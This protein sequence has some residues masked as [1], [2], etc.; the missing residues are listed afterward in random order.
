MKRL[1]AAAAAT[2]LVS[3]V[4]AQ[5]FEAEGARSAASILPANHLRSA[6]HQVAPTVAVRGNDYHFTIQTEW[7]PITASS[8]D[9]L[10]I[11]L[12]EIAAIQAIGQISK[13]EVYMTAAA[14]AATAPLRTAGSLITDPAGTI[15]SA[16]RGVASMLDRVGG[17]G[18]RSRHDDDVV[19][20][21]GGGASAK[22]EIAYAYRVS[23]YSSNPVLQAK[24][25]E[26]AQ[27]ATLGGFTVTAASLAVPGAAGLAFSIGRTTEDLTA[28]LRDKTPRELREA[29]RQTLLA[30][31]VPPADVE[32]FLANDAYS[33]TQQTY[34]VQSLAALRGVRQI[35]H[36]V[37]LAADAKDEDDAFLS[38]RIAQMTAG[39][40][41][42]VKR[43]TTLGVVRNVPLALT[44]DNVVLVLT[45]MDEV[46]WTPRIAH[47]TQA[48][49][50]TVTPLKP[51]RKELWIAGKISPAAKRELASRGWTVI[52]G[53]RGRLY[54]P[55]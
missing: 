48:V 21:V 55:I 5:Q 36:F 11:R 15:A 12:R 41:R 22:R 26:V 10:V 17:S 14:K 50:Q 7:G 31:G 34:L 38:Q 43:I 49:N 46:L 39:Y 23:P 27:A 6:L 51:V 19:S 16:P 4:Y 42:S 9:M 44:V 40:H 33:P 37:R 8:Y 30:L 35:D 29:N 28:A 13:T 45:P 47:L 32:R 2:L 3:P 54:D 53:A 1:L 25:N 52:A 18:P 24:L 20:T